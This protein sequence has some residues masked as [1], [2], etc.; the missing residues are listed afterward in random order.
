MT[1]RRFRPTL[2]VNTAKQYNSSMQQ[3]WTRGGFICGLGWP[4]PFEAWRQQLITILIRGIPRRLAVSVGNLLELQ[5]IFPCPTSSGGC[6]VE[7]VCEPVSCLAVAGRMARLTGRGYMI[8]S[9]RAIVSA[10][11]CLLVLF[12]CLHICSVIL[13][14]NC[15]MESINWTELNDMTLY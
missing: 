3:S 8:V 6:S 1:D 11:W 10:L 2:I 4:I 9:V 12:H 7:Y 14:F 13:S 5:V 15:G